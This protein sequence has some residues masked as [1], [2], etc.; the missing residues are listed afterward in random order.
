M[1]F[2]DLRS[3]VVLSRF[4]CISEGLRGYLCTT[5]RAPPESSGHLILFTTGLFEVEAETYS[6]E[7][8]L[9]KLSGYRDVFSSTSGIRNL[10]L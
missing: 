6:E 10:A 5:A 1:R 3:V 9:G 7:L 4:R 8:T 2:L